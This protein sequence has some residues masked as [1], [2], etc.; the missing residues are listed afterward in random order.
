MLITLFLQMRILFICVVLLVLGPLCAYSQQTASDP[1]IVTGNLLDEK[2][3]AIMGASVELIAL[4]DTTLRRGQVSDKDG[5]FSFNNV[6]FGLY[7][8]RVSSM[9]YKTIVI[10]SIHIRAERFDF[11]LPDIILKSASE[12]LQEVVV[13]AEK[14]LI[15]SKEGNITYNAA[16]SPLSAGSNASDLLKNVPLVAGDPNGKITVRGKEPKILIDDKPVELNAQ[17]LQ[18][19]L[20]SMPGSM[21]ERIEVMTNPPP[22]YANE[23]GGVINIVTRKGKVGKTGRI[24]IY[25]GTRGEGGVNG[26]FS[27]RKKGLSINFNAGMGYNVFEGYGY[28]RRQNIYVDSTNYLNTQND[29]RNKSYRPNGRLNVDYDINPRN[30][31]NAVV[32]YNHNDFENRSNTQFMN[33]DRFKN[34][35]KLS[36]RSILSDGNNINPSFNFTYTHR[37]KK[38]GETFRLFTNSWYSKNLNDRYFQQQF[39]NADFSPTGVDSS[40]QQFTKSNNHGYNVRVSYDKLLDNKL[41]SFSTGMY[42]NF[43]SSEVELLSQY[44]KKPEGLYVKSDLL[45]NDFRFR[46]MIANVRISGRHIISKG[47]SISVGM[48]AEQTR[49][50]FD[51]Y[52]S[53]QEAKND[54]WTI[55]PFFNFNKQWE[56]VLNLTFSYRRT[57]R[58]PGIGELNPSIDYSD[59]YNLRFGNTEL[60]PSTSHNFDLL[61]G[62]NRDKYYLNVGVGYNIVQD[63]FAQLRTLQPDGKTNVTWSNIDDR[64]E[65][66]IST[67]NGYTFSKKLR[68]NASVSYTY[69]KYSDADK[70]TYRYQDGGSFNS[71]FNGNYMPKD[72]WN[73][74][75][76]FTF[77]RFANPQGY[78]RWNSSMNMGIQRKFFQKRF[79]ITAN[80]IDPFRQQENRT[81]TSGTNFEHESYSYTQTR[82]YRLTLTYNFIQVPKKATAKEQA[83]KDRLRKMVR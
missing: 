77:N 50:H 59:P 36:R 51:L 73:F 65:Y 9:G 6:A 23:P 4:R 52:Q 37:G 20:E 54:Y 11:N 25:A 32:Q 67:W 30:T 79:I 70:K 58:R 66:E 12:Q 28:S 7:K 27:Y 47:T 81:F 62:R 55:L 80:V 19:F 41:T 10:D 61:L 56:E 35:S 49:V 74:N 53:K 17:Q 60:E 22:Q 24:N 8:L 2:Q 64:I 48:N 39:L 46:Q 69:N 18:D 15:Q 33:L 43:S 21:I 42:Y 13:Y 29:Y 5:G 34:I 14:P 45:S 63:V 38:P 78:V 71:N 1:G 75:A 3:S 31:I 57:I 26:N 76:G 68:I 16:E 44:L 40:Q 83:E 82:N 72:V